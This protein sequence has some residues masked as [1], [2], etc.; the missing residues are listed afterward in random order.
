MA[1]VDAKFKAAKPEIAIYVVFPAGSDG[2]DVFVEAGGE[3]YLPMARK[4]GKM[5]DGAVRFVIDLSN[6][7][8]VKALAGKELQ[9]TLVS[10][11]ESAEVSH[12]LP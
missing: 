10:D 2:G 11:A 1:R 5:P 7:I 8:D 6:G 4:M 12:R 3:T 9:L